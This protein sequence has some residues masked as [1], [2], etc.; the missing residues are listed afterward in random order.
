MKLMQLFK[1]PAIGVDV[2]ARTIKGVRLKRK[3]GHIYLD[4]YFFHDLAQTSSLYPE[5]NTLEETLRA[6]IEMTRLGNARASVNLRDE[7]VF[8]FRFDLPRLKPSEMRFAVAHEIQDSLNIPVED[9]TFDYVSGENPLQ[10]GEENVPVQAYCARRESVLQRIRLLQRTRLRPSAVESDMLA[11]AA[12]LRFNTYV[13]P[14]QNYAVFD[15]GES[16]ISMALISDLEVVHLKSGKIACGSINQALRESL[17]LSYLEGEEL[18]L[19]HDFNQK[20]GGDGAAEA[21]IDQV[22]LEIFK[23]IKQA[24]DLFR[25]QSDPVTTIDRILLVGGGSQVPNIDKV[26]EM[27]FRIPATVVNP[28]KNIQIFPNS[29][30]AK[31]DSIG[32]VGAFMATAVG[33]A[34]RDVA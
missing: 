7:D 27:L 11:I 29:Q 19:R 13:L 22:Y 18:K 31:D 4:R 23:E 30:A 1:A 14:K 32:K 34:L 15:L 2:G 20:E 26:F 21:V 6:N 8:S 9:L 28:L 24:L 5:E 12:M 33:L 10:P 16:H 25:E 3:K 17:D